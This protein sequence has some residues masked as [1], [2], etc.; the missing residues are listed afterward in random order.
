MTEKTPDAA[1]K[2]SK[3]VENGSIEF[4]VLFTMFQPLQG[5][6]KNYFFDTFRNIFGRIFGAPALTAVL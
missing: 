4:R 3:V 1:S 5:S 6:L 2:V